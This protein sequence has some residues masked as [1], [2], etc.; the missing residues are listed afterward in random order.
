MKI[1]NKGFTLVELMIVLSIIGV[2]FGVFSR[3]LSFENRDYI[4]GEGCVNHVYGEIK[5][6][7]DNASTGKGIYTGGND[8]EFPSLYSVQFNTGDNKVLF[9]YD[10]VS[11]T[12][13]D[14]KEILL[15]GTGRD[16]NFCFDE[17][18]GYHINIDKVNLDKIAM[19]K[20]LQ[21]DVKTSPFTLHE[22]NDSIVT[23]HVEFVF[24]KGDFKRIISKIEF[25]KR[26]SRIYHNKCVHRGDDYETC[27][28]WSDN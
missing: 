16:S 22:T 27:E 19:N 26:V 20:L 3:L 6:Y 28:T 8:L 7:F 13:Q 24:E 12:G 10:T 17:N 4:R 25:D 9:K 18:A 5:N 1:N 21:S 23:G 2:L 11:S 14:Y 15:S